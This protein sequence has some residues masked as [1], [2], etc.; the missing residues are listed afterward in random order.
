MAF[1]K[2][3]YLGQ[4]SW[5]LRT[6]R[7]VMH[8]LP[9][10]GAKIASVYDTERRFEYLFQPADGSYRVPNGQAAFSDHDTSGM[11]DMLPTIDECALT[12]GGHAYR[13]G[14]HGEA[15]RVPWLC[16]PDGDALACGVDLATM[17]LRFR[18]VIRA[19]GDDAFTLGY[20]LENLSDHELPCLWALH[21]LNTLTDDAELRV[22][23]PGE[24]VVSVQDS[25]FLGAAGSVHAYPRAACQSTEFDLSRPGRL[26]AGM[27]G[28]FYF[29]HGGGAG[30][31]SVVY[32]STGCA[33]R[34]DYDPS[35]L[36]ELGVW[37]NTGGFKNERNL[38]V[39]PSNAFYDRL[40]RAVDY[41]RVSRIPPR[42]SKEWI[43]R[44]T[45][46]SV[47]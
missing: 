37:I 5:M 6:R 23:R 11:D 10:L 7:F 38:A 2:A 30:T 22:P 20:R 21:A 46:A 19:D 32:P 31:A 12:A 34:I 36:P 29:S 15:W 25:G 28:K 42:G 47:D 41:G 27:T 3:S 40:D 16:V 44:I 1:S 18:R 45:L 13:L 4:E 14:D 8:V 39:E 35:D 17:P 43:I 33:W 9:G 26:P 24:P